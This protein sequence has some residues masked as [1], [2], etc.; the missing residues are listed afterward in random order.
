MKQLIGE[1]PSDKL[2]GRILY[3]TKFIEK[4]DIFNKNI[5]DI[6]CGFGWFELN[7]LKRKCKSIT[8]I[9]ITEKDLKTVKE[10]INDKRAFFKIGSA[11]DLPFKKNSFDTVVSWEVIEH[12]PKDKEEDMFKEIFRVL[13]PK[14]IFYLSTPNKSFISNIFD[15]AWWLI[16]HRHYSKN[17][18]VKHAKKNDFLLEKFFIRGGWWEIIGINDLYISKWIFRRKPFFK[19]FI[20]LKQ[21]YYHDKPGFTNIFFKFR[22]CK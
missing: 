12:I 19:N 3:S 1:N 10:N 8:G 22:R 9:E 2:H 18:L 11:I 5:L 20:E 13:K 14:G 21:D 15:P 4:K 17:D 6:G 16:G 7:T